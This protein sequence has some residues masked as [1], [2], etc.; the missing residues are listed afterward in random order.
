MDSKASIYYRK[1][2]YHN[3]FY[4]VNVDDTNVV[5]KVQWLYYLGSIQWTIKSLKLGSKIQKGNPSVEG[6]CTPLTPNQVVSLVHNI[7]H[8][9]EAWRHRM[10]CWMFNSLS[11]KNHL[12]DFQNPKEIEQLWEVFWIPSP[13]RPPG[14]G[15][16]HIIELEIGKQTIK[17]KPYICIKIIKDEIEEAN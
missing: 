8:Y 4:V 3:H 14:R 15:V 5:L 2:Y 9:I 16:E 17:M 13:G 12:K 6:E 10:G 1:S 7:G 11:Y